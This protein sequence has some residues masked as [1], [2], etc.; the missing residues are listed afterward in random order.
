MQTL[1]FVSGLHNCLEINI[2]F[3]EKCCFFVVYKQFSQYVRKCTEFTR[4]SA[5]ALINFF[6]QKCAAY[7]RAVLNTIVIPLSTVFIRILINSPA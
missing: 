1:D 4:I 2:A 3:L 6:L 5:A 7:L